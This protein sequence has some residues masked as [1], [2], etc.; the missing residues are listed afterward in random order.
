[1]VDKKPGHGGPVSKGGRGKVNPVKAAV[2]ADAKAGG[3]DASERTIKRSLAKAEGKKPK[4]AKP[5]KT[6][7]A[8]P[9]DPDYMRLL[10]AFQ[11]SPVATRQRFLEAHTKPAEI[12]NGTAAR[13]VDVQKVKAVATEITTILAKLSEADQKTLI[14][15]LTPVAPDLAWQLR[16]L[17]AENGDPWCDHGDQ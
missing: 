9:A 14:E 8:H 10:K 1:M 16:L 2:I 11:E 12:K 13:P 4:P 7:A 3:I 6:P 17:L 15:R 5:R